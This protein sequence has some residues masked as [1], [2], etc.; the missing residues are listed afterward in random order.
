[1]TQESTY[2][3]YSSSV[4][5]KLDAIQRSYGYYED[6]LNPST[7]YYAMIVKP[8]LN[9]MNKLMQDIKL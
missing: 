3:D 1:M 4:R 8:N 2:V 9:Y 7:F 6:R 5:Q